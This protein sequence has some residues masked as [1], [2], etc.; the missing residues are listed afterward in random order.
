MSPII[1]NMIMNR[2]MRKIPPEIGT[3]IES[4]QYNIMAFADDLFASTSTGL[5]RA[6]N[7]TSDYLRDCGLQINATKSFT[8]SVR[9]IPHIKKSIID[10]N[11]KFK[12]GSR[13]LP[14]LQRED[15]WSYLGV[16][17]SPTGRSKTLELQKLRK[18]LDSLTSALLKP[19]QRLFGLRSIVLPSVYHRLTLGD[20]ILGSLKKFDNL[21]RRTVRKWLDLPHDVCNAYIHA[22]SKDGGLSI[23]SMRWLMP[24]LRR[25][26]LSAMLIPNEGTQSF[27]RNELEKSV[28]RLRI[29]SM[30][31]DRLAKLNKKWSDNLHTSVDG[32]GLEDSRKVPQQN[33][34]VNDGTRFLSG[35]DYINSIKQRIN[36]LPSRS[37]TGRGRRTNRY[38]RAGCHE[39]ETNGHILQRCHRTHDNR[40][41]RHNGLVAH[42]KRNLVNQGYTVEAEP[43]FRMPDGLRKPDLVAIKEQKALILDVQVVM[44]TR[45]LTRHTIEK[46]HIITTYSRLPKKDTGYEAWNSRA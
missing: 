33:S 43:H 41:R 37:R 27:L 9:N 16:P 23:P 10:R 30:D 44:N 4:I 26:C 15:Q 18:K 45:I 20:T 35:R 36:A 29:G 42:I 11:I 40:I 14:T 38:C 46:S 22:H 21:I 31:I 3:N 25:N 6:I 32:K 7:I 19:Q 34:W 39:V 1:F 2:L 17:F 5:Q 28:K 13:I 24:L 8:I 12:C